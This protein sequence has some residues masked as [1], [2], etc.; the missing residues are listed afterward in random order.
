MWFPK[1]SCKGPERLAVIARRSWAYE[2]TAGL[3]FLGI[4][5]VALLA[6][7]RHKKDVIGGNSCVTPG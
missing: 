7:R 4:A 6:A 2:A 3:F 1:K 5:L